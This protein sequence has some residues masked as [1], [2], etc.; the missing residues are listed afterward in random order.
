VEFEV[1]QSAFTVPATA[2]EASSAMS[3]TTDC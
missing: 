1:T 2:A 3:G